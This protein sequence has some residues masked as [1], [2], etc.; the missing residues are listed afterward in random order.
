MAKGFLLG[1]VPLMAAGVVLYHSSPRYKVGSC[2]R[3]PFGP[4]TATGIMGQQGA[5]LGIG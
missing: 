3:L 5:G 2:P 4:P 1:G